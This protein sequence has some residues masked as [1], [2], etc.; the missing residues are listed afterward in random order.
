[1][2]KKMGFDHAKGLIRWL[3]GCHDPFVDDF[4]LDSARQYI[5]GTALLSNT[6]R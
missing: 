1:M 5:E 3:K 6:A 4:Q 2:K